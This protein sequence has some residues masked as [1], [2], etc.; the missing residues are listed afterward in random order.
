MDL[1]EPISI[2][3]SDL[4]TKHREIM[5]RVKYFGDVFLIKTFGQP[6]A[7]IISVNDFMRMTQRLTEEPDQTSSIER[8][9]E[10]TEG[11]N[12]TVDGLE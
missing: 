3:S 7:V 9:D 1:P 5:E 10:T 2:N 12:A 6:T 4:R 11:E 8:L